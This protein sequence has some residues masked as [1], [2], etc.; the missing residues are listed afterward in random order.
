MTTGDSD[1]YEKP[2][3][4]AVEREG[5][6]VYLPFEQAAADPALQAEIAADA[7]RQAAA[8]RD[9]FAAF[10]ALTGHLEAMEIVHA[11]NRAGQAGSEEPDQQSGLDIA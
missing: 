6:V 5:Q 11:I 2:E 4:I 10:F 3:H 1:R 7:M 8:W 9:R